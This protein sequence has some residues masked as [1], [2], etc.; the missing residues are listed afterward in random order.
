MRRNF[1]KAGEVALEADLLHHR[2]HL[3]ADALDLAQ[4]GLVDLLRREVEG[5]ELADLVAVVRAAVRQL[6]RA[7]RRAR[8]GEVLVAEEV[9]EVAR[10]RRPRL[11]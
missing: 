3:R 5:R 9:E 1:R 2:V 6:G 10:S 4:A 11:R 7:E 8:A